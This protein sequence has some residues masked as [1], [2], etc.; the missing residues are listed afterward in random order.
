MVRPRRRKREREHTIARLSTACGIGPPRQRSRV[1]VRSAGTPRFASSLQVRRAPAGNGVVA[2]STRAISSA[3]KSAWSP[4]SPC[5]CRSKV[6]DRPRRRRRHRQPHPVGSGSGTESLSVTFRIRDP[7][8]SSKVRATN[9][10]GAFDTTAR[11]L[12]GP[13]LPNASVLQQTSTRT[14]AGRSHGPVRLSRTPRGR[15]ADAG[16]VWHKQ[17]EVRR[18]CRT[19]AG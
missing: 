7:L 9:T 8:R 3:S 15:H 18:R 11:R 17:R 13:G 4:S 16:S 10:A 12:F 6:V 5:V 19:R 1:R 14:Q 2:R